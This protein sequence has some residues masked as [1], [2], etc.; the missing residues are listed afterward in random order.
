MKDMLKSII[1]FIGS[2]DFLILLT[3]TLAGYIIIEKI[4]IFRLEPAS[5]RQIFHSIPIKALSILFVINALTGLIFFSVDKKLRHKLGFIFFFLSIFLFVTGLWVSVY[6]RFEGRSFVTE[7]G[8]FTAFISEYI[9]QTLHMPKKNRLPKV[10][11]TILKLIP[12]PSEDMRKMEK[13]TA[14][15]LY[16]SS[17]TKMIHNGKL[18]SSWPF[19]SDW[20]FMRITD[21]GY[22]VKYSSQDL[23]EIEQEKRYLNMK[24]FPSG[25]EEHFEAMFLGYVF[26]VRCYPDYVKN[27]GNPGSL[28]AYPRNPVFN[29]RIVRNKDIVF[30][31]LLKPTEKVRFDNQV[32]SLSDVKMWVEISF[33]RDPG[34]PVIAV[35]LVLMMTGV[36]L[37]FMR[38]R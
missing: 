36:V 15:I 16:S 18:S 32:I 34:L 37:M 1:R 5:H 33:V 3:L 9:P 27:N 30:N 19:I 4:G 31:G 13:V 7:G 23:N 20:T 26:Y 24:L 28:S 22:S 2:K 29:L 10:G 38:R 11:L 21:F 35:G 14:D 25:A 8:S 12:E 17:T 6:T